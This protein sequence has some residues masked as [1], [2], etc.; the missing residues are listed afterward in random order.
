MAKGA[1]ERISPPKN[2][3]ARGAARTLLNFSTAELFQEQRMTA[4]FAPLFANWA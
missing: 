2:D 4:A 3:P 1:S